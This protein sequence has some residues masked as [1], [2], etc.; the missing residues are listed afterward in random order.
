MGIDMSVFADIFCRMRDDILFSALG[1]PVRRQVILLLLEHERTAGALAREFAIARSSVSEH[2]AILRNANVVHERKYGRERVYSLNAEPLIELQTW[3]KPIEAYW[4]TQ[5][6][7]L[8]HQ[9]ED[10]NDD[11]PN[12]DD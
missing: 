5:L 3:L 10:N 11:T 2:L 7:A 6:L 1:H 9:F 12:G 4:K 8:S